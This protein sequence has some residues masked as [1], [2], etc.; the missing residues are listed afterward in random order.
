MGNY[1]VLIKCWNCNSRNTIEQVQGQGLPPIVKC[2]YCKCITH[3]RIIL[4]PPADVSEAMKE[5]AEAVG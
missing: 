1:F 5:L 4:G 2:R 3:T